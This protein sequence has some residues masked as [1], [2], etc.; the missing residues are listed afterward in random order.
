MLNPLSFISKIF[1]SSN[2]IE[3]AKFKKI[4]EKINSLEKSLSPK[5]FEA[6]MAK[7][8]PKNGHFFTIFCKSLLNMPK[9]IM[10]I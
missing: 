5:N 9:N 6:K 1:K 10:K 3:L 4:L 7:K 8:G 2:E